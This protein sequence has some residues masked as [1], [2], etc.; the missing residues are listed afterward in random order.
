MAGQVEVYRCNSCGLVR[1]AVVRVGR[2]AVYGHRCVWPL[3][4]DCW[5]RQMT[6]FPRY[7][8]PITLLKTRSGRC[9]EWANCFTFLCR[10]M[11]FDAR[12]VHD[13]TDHVWTEVWATG[14]K[15]G[16]GPINSTHARFTHCVMFYMLSLL[17]LCNSVGFTWIP[18][19]PPTMAL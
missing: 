10:A 6:R 16:G 5:V 3:M 18:A 14:D 4:P 19:R 9:G 8:N 15:V 13:W 12:H 2:V 7:N 1:V 17:M 11:G